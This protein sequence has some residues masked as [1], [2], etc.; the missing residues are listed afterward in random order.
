[1]TRE[2]MVRETISWFQHTDQAVKSVGGSGAEVVVRGMSDALLYTMVA[3]GLM[4]SPKRTSDD[5]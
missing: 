3:N 2:G 4:I 1:M 5:L